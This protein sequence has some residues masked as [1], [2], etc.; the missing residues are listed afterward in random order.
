MS[1]HP[2]LGVGDPAGEWLGAPPDA[3]GRR[4]VWAGWIAYASLLMIM[5]GSFNAIEGLAGVLVDDFYVAAPADVL[6]F[7]LTTW[8]W[9]HLVIGVLVALT[10]AALLTGAVWARVV[11]VV[12]AIH[13]AI[14]QLAFA[15]VYPVWSLIVI[16]LCVTV[17]WA[18]VVHGDDVAG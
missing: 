15:A 2:N 9:L 7:D 10:G 14:A 1:E 18:V 17:I 16:G 4:S 12:L 11:T 3:R 6:V 5:M 13:N 8:G